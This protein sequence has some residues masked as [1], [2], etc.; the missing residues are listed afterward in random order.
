MGFEEMSKRSVVTA[1]DVAICTNELRDEPHPADRLRADLIKQAEESERIAD[2][3]LGL[4]PD[5]TWMKQA[6]GWIDEVFRLANM[7][8]PDARA[9]IDETTAAARPRI[10]LEIAQRYRQAGDKLRGELLLQLGADVL[11]CPGL[12]PFL[13][14]R[15]LGRLRWVLDGELKARGLL[16]PDRGGLAPYPDL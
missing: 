16:L 1:A 12:H 5:E 7:D 9:W 14:N 15:V 10:R 8:H 11:K 3:V 2:Y 6:T 13:R 4:E